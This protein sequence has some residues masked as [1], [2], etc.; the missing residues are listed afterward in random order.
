[1]KRAR[2]ELDRL[3][4]AAWGNLGRDGMAFVKKHPILSLGGSAVLAAVVVLGFRRGFLKGLFRTAG[5]LIR[6]P[7][8]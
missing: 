2:H 5:L 1:M 8:S 3:R 7:P 4:S 6:R